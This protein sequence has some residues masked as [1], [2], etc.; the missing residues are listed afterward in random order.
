[1]AYQKLQ[2]KG[3]INVVPDDN[4]IVPGPGGKVASGTTD[5]GAAN[6]LIDSTALFNGKVKL[7]ATVYNTAAN[8]VATV[9]SVSQ[10]ELGL[11][12]NITALA[13]ITYVIYNTYPSEGPV[14]FVGTGGDL[15]IETVG[16]DTVLLK[17]LNNASFIPI[18]VNKVLLTNTSCSDIVALW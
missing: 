17:N 4:V 5:G 10:T 8:T 6:K 16:G 3:A 11:S 15:N 1:M 18:M 14:L 2:G 13:G 9:T 12:A 7:G